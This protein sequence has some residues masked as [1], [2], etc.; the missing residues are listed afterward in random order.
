MNPFDSLS[1]DQLQ[2]LA[3]TSFLG[4]VALVVVACIEIDQWRRRPV[5]A[6]AA[7]PVKAS[8]FV[9]MYCPR[10]CAKV[11]GDRGWVCPCCGQQM[12]T[13]EEDRALWA[14]MEAA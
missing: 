13:A 9:W 4:I 3:A 10:R 14:S 6:K 7:E 11:L 8:A 1:T 2:E 5:V 12:K